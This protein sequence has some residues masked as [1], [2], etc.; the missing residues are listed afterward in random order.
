MGLPPR[1][2]SLGGITW[3]VLQRIPLATPVGFPPMDPLGEPLGDPWGPPGGGPG[4]PNGSTGDSQGGVPAGDPPGD[5]LRSLF[6]V[7]SQGC[8][9]DPLKLD[10]F[11]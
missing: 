1:G 3:V 5:P 4:V 7:I 8:P 9:S 2:R 11:Y 10:V 6:G